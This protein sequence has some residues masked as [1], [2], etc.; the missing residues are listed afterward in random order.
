MGEGKQEET[1][2]RGEDFGFTPGEM[3]AMGI[4]SRGFR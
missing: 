3:G 4:L 2:E 1:A